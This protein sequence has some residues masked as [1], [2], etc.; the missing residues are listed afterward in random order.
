MPT[1]IDESGETGL[2]SPYFRLAAV[3]LPTQADVEAYRTGIQQFQR[4]IGL[5]GYEFKSSKSLSLERRVAFFQAAMAHP[6]RFAV[7]TV[8]KHHSEWGAA[9]ASVVHW[10][11]V[12]S[13]AGSLRG[14]YLAEETRR[15]KEAGGDYPLSELVIVDDNKDGKFLKI[16][17]QKLRELRSGVRAGSP[18]V[19]KVKFRGSG[20]E[21]LIQLVDMVCGAVGDYL[22]GDGTCYNIIAAR[23]LGITHI[24]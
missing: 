20:P 6:F 10:A 2:V 19:G 4:E 22:D 24:P 13:L 1:F 16:I 14:V 12:V 17:K 23:D 5:E 18:L 3:W 11:C 21:E 7:A 9:G 15:V 8:D